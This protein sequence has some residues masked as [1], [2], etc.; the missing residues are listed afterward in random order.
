VDRNDSVRRRIAELW[1][2]GYRRP[3]EIAAMLGVP[4]G[5]VKYYMWA[6]RREGLLPSGDAHRDLLE[7][8][9][10]ELKGAAV[11]SSYLL[12]E[13]GGGRHEA[14]LRKLRDY[15]ERASQLVRMYRSVRGLAA[16]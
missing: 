7:Q 4:V 13:L 2:R 6:M 10:T 8:A 16:R 15:V 5:R 12:H 3:S 11:V 9:L 14:E 1:D